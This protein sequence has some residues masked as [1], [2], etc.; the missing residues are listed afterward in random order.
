MSA[1]REWYVTSHFYEWYLDSGRSSNGVWLLSIMITF[2]KRFCGDKAIYLIELACP[3]T[4]IAGLVALLL[5]FE[6]A[7]VQSP[8]ISARGF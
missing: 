8:T 2:Y 1:Q 6:I 3:M 5:H 4:L 7:R